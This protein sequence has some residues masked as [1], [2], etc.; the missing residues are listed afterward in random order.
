VVHT[1][2]VYPEALQGASLHSVSALGAAGGGTCR[3]GH[4]ICQAVGL[5][6]GGA[7]ALLCRVG[8]SCSC[9]GGC[10]DGLVFQ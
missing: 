6:G 4:L 3:L 5:R 1:Q 7:E 2:A 10:M 9:C 8:S